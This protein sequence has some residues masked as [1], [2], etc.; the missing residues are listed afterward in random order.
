MAPQLI[1]EIVDGAAGA[2]LAVIGQLQ[3]PDAVL[4]H[5][6]VLE[7]LQ[8]VQEVNLSEDGRE[9]VIGTTSRPGEVQLYGWGV[10]IG[11]H[12]DRTGIVYGVCLNPGR[13][14]L[15]STDERTTVPG[16]V[17]QVLLPAGAVF[18]LDD[19]LAH[20]TEDS[21]PRVAAFCGPFPECDDAAALER[22]QAAIGLLASGTYAGAP[23]ISAGFIQLAADEAW[24]TTDF[25]N[26]EI[27]LLQEVKR[28]R[29]Y[30]LTCHLCDR[31]AN[32]I[33]HFWPYHEEASRCLVCADL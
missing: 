23:R 10:N 3:I 2:P 26:R 11:R 13:T 32:K 8:R 4:Q 14:V 25:E 15:K 18:R 27:M 7:A 28:R 21:C 1:E 6:F 5:R 30:I 19:Y 24:A 16:P 29:A 20:W 33:D 12:T 17:H 9:R 31:P 22:L